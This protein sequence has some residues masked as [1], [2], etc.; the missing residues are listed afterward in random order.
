MY[1]STKYLEVD[2]LRRS[3]GGLDVHL[4]NVL[5]LLLE[6]RSQ[7]V[8]SKLNI[9]NDLLLLHAD[10]GNSNVEAHDLLHLELDGGPNFVN[11]F[12]HVL[13]T[14]KKGGEFT[15]LGKTGTQ[16]TWDLLDHVIG[17]K[18]E[19]VLLGKLLNKLLVLVELLE[20]FD[21]HVVNSDTVSLLTVSSITK[22]AALEVGTRDLRK[23]EGSRETLV[24]LRI[25][26]LQGDLD[27]NGLSEVTLLSFLVTNLFTGGIGKNVIN[28]LVEEG[29]V[30]LV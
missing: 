12:L 11:F 10:V 22:H 14:G 20:V 2:L 6:K 1:L 28:G 30:Q 29:R 5:P 21:T 17:S 18:E 13:S 8:S 19:I 16:K 7:E 9:D 26:V 24:T 15:S 27:F 25:I 3:H 4:S 23:L